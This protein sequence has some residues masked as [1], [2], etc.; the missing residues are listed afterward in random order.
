M[1]LATG[2]AALAQDTPNVQ[3]KQ[4]TSADVDELLKKNSQIIILDVRTPDEFKQGHLKNAINLNIQ[5]PDALEK[6]GKL[7]HKATY[8]VYCRT[9]RRSGIA[10]S[11]MIE[12]GFSNV[13]H[14]TDGMSGWLQNGKS[15]EK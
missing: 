12:S 14:M 11:H 4:V 13:Y 6:I 9:Q 7:D 2:L 3:A 10:V 1:V 8:L 5:D 15:V